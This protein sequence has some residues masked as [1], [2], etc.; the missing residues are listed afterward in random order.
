MPVIRA[1]LMLK[2][3]K[4]AARVV[5]TFRPVKAKMQTT[6]IPREITNAQAV[7][8]TRRDS[9]DAATQSHELIRNTGGSDLSPA[10]AV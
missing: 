4:N 10:A 5:P 8:S 6:E 3:H 1:K 9:V 2:M 7:D